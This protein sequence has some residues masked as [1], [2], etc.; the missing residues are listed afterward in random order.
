MKSKISSLSCGREEL[1][2]RTTTSTSPY[3]SEIGSA[4]S[5]WRG[6]DNLPRTTLFPYLCFLL[7]GRTASPQLPCIR[8]AFAR[9]T[10]HTC[11]PAQITTRFS[12]ITLV[13]TSKSLDFQA[14]LL[15]VIVACIPGDELPIPACYAVFAG[16]RRGAR[17]DKLPVAPKVRFGTQV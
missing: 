11:K 12:S 15:S 4:S 9:Q 1:T 16:A 13:L 5:M 17:A 7:R 14:R 8:A 2:D 10:S 6:S 3:N